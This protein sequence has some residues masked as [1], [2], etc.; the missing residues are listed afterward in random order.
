MDR[1]H[2]GR[3]VRGECKRQLLYKFLLA[4]EGNRA[5]TTVPM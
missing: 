1:F 5:L 3:R 4:I 2:L